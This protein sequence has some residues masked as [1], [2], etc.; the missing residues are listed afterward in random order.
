MRGA[1]VLP[2][3]TVLLISGFDP[4]GEGLGGLFAWDGTGMDGTG[5]DGA[6]LT[7]LD[8][9]CTTGLH[10]HDGSLLRCLWHRGGGYADLEATSVSGRQWRCRIENV[11]NPHDVLGDGELTAVV[12]TE[13]NQVTWFRRDGTPARAW[14]PAGEADSWHLNS[15]VVHEGRLLVCA[16]G[17][18]SRRKEWDQL[19]QPATGCL[20]DTGTGEVV[21][22]GLRAPHTPRQDGGDWLICNSA[23]GEL[24]TVGPRGERRVVATFRGWPRGLAVTPE[25]ICV[26]VSPPR[27][28]LDQRAARSRVTALDR[29]TG[30]I[31]AGTDVPAR[32]VYDLVLV[33]A[34]LAGALR[35]DPLGAPAPAHTRR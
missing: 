25:V 7:M 13:Q 24:L 9:R 15:L 22:A 30:D 14:R 8:R 20:V 12:A 11:G 26:G 23:D 19:G 31:I 5:T 33:P 34:A 27:H 1:S 6:G 16:F 35:S 3:G 18:F 21:L 32:E 29:A 17:R 2:P 28:E 10:L 4:R